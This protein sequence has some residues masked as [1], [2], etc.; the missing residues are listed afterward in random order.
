MSKQHK[1]SYLV[2]RAT[3]H[4]GQV[5]YVDRLLEGR[6]LKHPEA[7]QRFLWH[8]LLSRG[9]ARPRQPKL[10]PVSAELIKRELEVELTKD[11]WWPLVYDAPQLVTHEYA[12]PRSG[13]SRRFRTLDWVVDGFDAAVPPVGD[14]GA[15]DLRD[16]LSRRRSRRRVDQQYT[17]DPDGRR[18]PDLVVAALKAY[19]GSPCPVDLAAG[20]AHVDALWSDYQA[21]RDGVEPAGTGDWSAQA[22]RLRWLSDRRCLTSMIKTRPEHD[23]DVWWYRSWYRRGLQRN[24]RITE[25]GGLQ[26]CSRAMRHAMLARLRE[27]HDVRNFDL[28]QSQPMIYAQLLEDAG[29]NAQWLHSVL[30]EDRAQLAERV[31][32]ERSDRAEKAWKL[33]LTAL[34]MGASM[35]NHTGSLNRHGAREMSIATQLRDL[36]GAGRRTAESDN[37]LASLREAV[38]P[39]LAMRKELEGWLDRETR[40][41]GSLV[42]HGS[43][44]PVVTNAVGVRRRLQDSSF[45]PLRRKMP[46]FLLQGYEAA[47]VYTLS[48]LGRDFGFEAANNQHDGL[49]T[50]GAIPAEAVAE[51]KASVGLR[52]AVLVEKPY[53]SRLRIPGLAG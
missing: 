10:V 23:G 35:P 14:P 48:V 36:F 37:A 22:A 5:A 43:K 40:P 45:R 49:I 30:G 50:M 33:S 8:L 44:G 52:Y 18:Y 27:S 31:F 25:F 39:L 12:N 32:G 6:V 7:T 17:T 41:G 38:R 21:A 3:V 4:G 16:T 11:V 28:A 29:I 53:D 26:G 46:A 47:L 1:R 19:W 42:T 2:D 34:V 13:L 15:F 24:G 20:Q 9:R 51:A